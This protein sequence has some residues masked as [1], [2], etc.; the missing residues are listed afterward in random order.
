[1]RLSTS[2]TPGADQAACSASSRSAHERTVP[3]RITLSPSTSVT[4][5]SASVSALRTRAS[6]I[7]RCSSSGEVLTRGLTVMRLVTPRT[8]DNRRTASSA[9]RFSYC[10]ST[11]PRSVTQPAEA[12]DPA[13][14]GHH[15]VLDGDADLV[16]LDA[17]VPFHLFQHIP[18]DLLI[19]PCRRRRDQ[20]RRRS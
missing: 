8:P 18:L 2:A 3:L 10:H 7:L 11:S 17:G 19:G 6:S 5:R 4:I 15:A 13:R 9:S 12:V 1:M 16:G 20:R 14:E